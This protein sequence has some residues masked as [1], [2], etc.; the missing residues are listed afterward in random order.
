MFKSLAPG[1]LLATPPLTDPSFKQT[2]VLLFAHTLD[3]AMGL[4]INRP[5]RRFLGEVVDSAGLECPEATLRGRRVFNG[6][7]VQSESGWVVFEG[8][9]TRGES[10]SIAGDLR[11]TGSLDVFKELLRDRN[12]G[13]MMFLLGY[14]GWGPGQLDAE[15]EGGSWMPVPPRAGTIFEIPVEERWRYAYLECGIDPNLWSPTIGD[16]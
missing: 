16:G 9:D 2:V 12:R 8:P 6:G 13:R 15:V 7:P 11:V 3:G 1:F 4:V 14:S 10:F 5:S